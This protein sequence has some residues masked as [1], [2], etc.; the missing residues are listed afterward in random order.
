MHA[1]SIE[2]IEAN[3]KRFASNI[4]EIELDSILATLIAS[5]SNILTFKGNERITKC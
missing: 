5:Q 1:K 3:I 4:P 2:E